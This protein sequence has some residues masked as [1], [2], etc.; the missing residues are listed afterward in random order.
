ME[1]IRKLLNTLENEITS[2]EFIK[3]YEE[4][5]NKYP[6]IK[7]Y[8][9]PEELLK[10]LHNQNNF[11]YALNDGILS[12]L[13]LEYQTQP[14]SKLIGAYLIVL[15]KPGLLRIFSQ[16][17]LRARQFP[18]LSSL[19]LW[20]QIITLFFT[21]LK[22]LDFAKDKSKI[23]AKI[24]GRIKNRLRDYF[25]E[26]FKALSAEYE[27]KANPE[28]V[29]SAPA[30]LNPEEI[31]V[32]LQELVDSGII[33]ETDKYILLASGVYGESMKDLSKKLKGVSYANI[34]QKKARAQKAIARYCAKKNL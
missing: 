25:K 15:F 22:Q 24:L 20:L 29:S 14:G 5:R 19:D 3:L 10:F 33:S 13:I 21:E 4:T 7:S 31:N 30:R 8:L 17:R 32:F 6:L 16:F 23:A 12:S 18:C 2:A 26:L 11:D 34:R 27:L 28:I 1:A 9:T